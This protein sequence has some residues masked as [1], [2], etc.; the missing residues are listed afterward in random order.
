[1]ISVELPAL[2]LTTTPQVAI[3]RTVS[4]AAIMFCNTSNVD[5]RVTVSDNQVPPRYLFKNYK[6]IANDSAGVEFKDH[7]LSMKNGL[8]L[9]ADTPGVIDVFLTLYGY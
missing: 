8:Q 5:A 7:G 2:Q 6:I 1:M 3:S 4:L 9:S